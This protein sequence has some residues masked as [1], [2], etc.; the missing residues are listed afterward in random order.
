[1]PAAGRMDT[2]RIGS[3]RQATKQRTMASAP[4]VRATAGTTSGRRAGCP[5][6]GTCS[7]GLAARRAAGAGLIRDGRCVMWKKRRWLLAG[8]MFLAGIV[9]YMDRSAL[10]IAAPVMSPDLSLSPV[11]LGYVF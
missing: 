3:F 4:V 10:S 2:F 7:I 6:G 5:S 11:E 1:M 8:L 9:N